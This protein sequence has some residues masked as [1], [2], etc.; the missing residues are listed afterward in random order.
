MVMKLMRCD[1]EMK[2]R[3]CQKHCSQ[4]LFTAL[5]L[6]LDDGEWVEKRGLEKAQESISELT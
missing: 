1:V 2:C 6:V 5:L 3:S 4:C